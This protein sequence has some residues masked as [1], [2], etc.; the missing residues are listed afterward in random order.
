MFSPKP[1]GIHQVYTV[2]L[3]LELLRW[4]VGETNAYSSCVQLV[5][6]WNV[7]TWYSTCGGCEHSWRFRRTASKTAT[8]STCWKQN[9]HHTWFDDKQSWMVLFPFF[10]PCL[11]KY[12]LQHPGVELTGDWPTTWRRSW[13]RKPQRRT[14]CQTLIVDLFLPNIVMITWIFGPSSI[15]PSQLIR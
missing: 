13:Y 14:R 6:L 11:C 12:F 3:L 10:A 8:G 1:F 2:Y 5:E 4:D 9:Q 15:T 7:G